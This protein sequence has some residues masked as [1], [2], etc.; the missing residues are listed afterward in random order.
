MKLPI[1]QII[2]GPRQR[3]D[4]G[5]ITALAASLQANGQIQAI[6]VNEKHELIWGSRRLAAATSLEWDS[7]EVVVREGLSEMDNQLIEL[8]EDV[9]RKDRTWQEE[10]I[11]VAKIHSLQCISVPGW[12]VRKSA[13][14]LKF[15]IGH[16]SKCTTMAEFL[17]NMD[18]KE[19]WACPSYNSAYL[20]LVDRQC[21]LA[22]AELEKRRAKTLAAAVPATKPIANVH[23]QD[24][25][26]NGGVAIDLSEYENGEPVEDQTIRIQIVALKSLGGLDSTMVKVKAALMFNLKNDERNETLSN[27]KRLLTDDGAAILWIGKAFNIWMKAAMDAGFSVLPYPIIW[28]TQL[29]PPSGVYPFHASYLNGIVLMNPGFLAKSVSLGVLTDRWNPDHIPASI[30]EYSLTPLVAQAEPVLCTGK[31]ATEVAMIGRSPV[32]YETDQKMMEEE[33][34]RLKE[35]YRETIP[36]VEFFV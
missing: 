2:I 15:S 19:L 24:V 14:L 20:L 27:L 23:V 9:D 26:I 12:T 30:V 29:Q 16:I 31:C 28:N 3:V 6:G 32:Y 25:N 35:H 10:V 13:F 33:V 8:A 36:N 21:K 1:N 5:D 22:T 18:D 11:A 4:L 7:I 17:S 34:E